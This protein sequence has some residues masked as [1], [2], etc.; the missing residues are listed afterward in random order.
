MTCLSL[1]PFW[2]TSRP[3]PGRYIKNIATFSK[4]HIYVSDFVKIRL[5]ES[6]KKLVT[7]GRLQDFVNE[8]TQIEILTNFEQNKRIQ[9]NNGRTRCRTSGD[10]KSALRRR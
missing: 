5:Q 7:T 10:S 3:M 1:V 6:G 9:N 8:A 4:M 2:T